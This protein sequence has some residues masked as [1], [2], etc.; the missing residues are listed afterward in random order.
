MEFIDK[1]F[2]FLGSPTKAFNK[3]KKTS[4]SDAFKYL[5]FGSLVFA[6]ILTIVGTLVF[7]LLAT[8]LSAF[9]VMSVIPVNMLPLLGGFSALFVVGLF[10]I[11]F[12]SMIVVS[13]IWGI[14]L[15]VWVYIFGA[16]KGLENTFKALFYGKSPTYIL[17]WI[18]VVNIFVVLWEFVLTGVGLTKLHGISS[19]RTAAAIIIALIIP[20]VI[21]ASIALMSSSLYN[22]Y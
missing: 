11:S 15:H 18:P 1:L 22:P 7:S 21:I 3:E 16:R 17:F 10:V 8:M 20:I 12:V 9:G 6:I 19:G 4:M 5:V 13:L 14:W 2:A